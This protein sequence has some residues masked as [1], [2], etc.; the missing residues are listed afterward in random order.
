LRYAPVALERLEGAQVRRGN[1][2]GGDER[3]QA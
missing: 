3:E 2:D 1:G